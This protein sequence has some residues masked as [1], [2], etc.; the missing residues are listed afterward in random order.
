MLGNLGERFARET[1]RGRRRRECLERKGEIGE[2]DQP[3]RYR[4][5]T[6]DEANKEQ[7]VAIGRRGDLEELDSW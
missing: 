4:C 1:G 2:V 3:G 6:K 5:A 7:R